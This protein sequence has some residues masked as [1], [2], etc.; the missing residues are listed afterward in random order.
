MTH[1]STVALQHEIKIV[2]QELE[3]HKTRMDSLAEYLR[4][5]LEPPLSAIMGMSDL[6]Q[7]SGLSGEQVEYAQVIRMSAAIME[8][9]VRGLTDIVQP[10]T[11]TWLGDEQNFDL[12]ILVDGLVELSW[13]HAYRRNITFSVRIA[14]DVPSV[15][16]GYPNALRRILSSIVQDALSCPRGS[17]LTLGVT[18]DD[19]DEDS[20]AVRFTLNGSDLG[21]MGSFLMPACQD[22][23]ATLGGVAGVDESGP[24]STIWATIKLRL[25]DQQQ[26]SFPQ[27][28]TIAGKRVLVVDLN[29][30]WREVLREYCFLWHCEC[31]EAADGTEALKELRSAAQDKEPFDFVLLNTSMGNITPAQFAQ[32]VRAEGL[33]HTRLVMLASSAQPGD[34]KRLEVAGF[35]GYL[36]KPITRRLLYDTLRLIQGQA[37]QGRGNRLVTR[38]IVAEEQKRRRTVLVVDDCQTSCKVVSAMLGQAG[39]SVKVLH[40]GEEAINLL[41]S[42]VFSMVLLDIQLTGASGFEVMRSIR[43]RQS[44]ILDHDVPVIALTAHGTQHDPQFKE[45]GFTAVLEK[46]F[47][48][49]AC[50]DLVERYSRMEENQETKVEL[51]LLDVERLLEQLDHDRKLLVDVVET[52]LTEATTRCAEFKQAADAEDFSLAEQ[53]AHA[54]HSMAASVRANVVALKAEMA[55]QAGRRSHQERCLILAR[56]LEQELERIRAL[57][58]S[59]IR[60]GGD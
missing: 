19:M 38:H 52:F 58:P 6:L 5:E 49:Q 35:L 41:A 21:N 26:P 53:K 43:D 30:T 48:A 37:E 22:L 25:P 34:A 13:L 60:H 44:A 47:E 45:A 29:R 8:S 16:R 54:L 23:A 31:A 57:L 4:Q 2:R 9:V 11:N 18:L 40:S 27:P 14:D 59:I 56:E 55:E 20:A 51:H 28:L 46:P 10:E 3:L 32:Q 1:H 33:E 24:T 15:V 12:R 36:V 42:E 17:E 39:I 7:E 50:L